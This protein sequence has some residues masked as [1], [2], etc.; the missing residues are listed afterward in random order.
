VVVVSMTATGLTIAD[1]S[2]EGVLGVGGLDGACRNWRESRRQAGHI[3][4]RFYSLSMP[5]LRM[6]VK[7]LLLAVVALVVELAALAS[8][9]DAVA[10]A[11]AAA[12]LLKAR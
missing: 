9:L 12:R 11:V 3:T 7:P 10:V 2:A 1:P 8:A 4:G 6:R 5:A